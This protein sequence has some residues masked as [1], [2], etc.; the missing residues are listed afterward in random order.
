MGKTEDRDKMYELGAR[1]FTIHTGG[2]TPDLTELRE[3]L[4]WRDQRNA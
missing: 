1:L 4:T 2:P 3:F